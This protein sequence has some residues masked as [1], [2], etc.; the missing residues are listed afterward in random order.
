MRKSA[1]WSWTTLS[2]RAS[3]PNYPHWTGGSHRGA[4]N[5]R[6][7][8][9]Q[10]HSVS[11][12]FL[13]VFNI[14]EKPPASLGLSNTNLGRR[15]S[16]ATHRAPSQSRRPTS[17]P[18]GPPDQRHQRSPPSQ[19]ARCYNS[20]KLPR[21]GRRVAAHFRARPS[22]PICDRLPGKGT[23]ATT[24]D[25]HLPSMPTDPGHQTLC[26]TRSSTRSGLGPIR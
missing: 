4:A 8:E 10:H 12:S 15:R 9:Q 26:R 2:A 24:F 1:G 17:D 19:E 14:D 3:K 18:H 5:Q 23:L 20:L 16:V 21:T 25:R 6:P 22:T 11:S 7:G 13:S